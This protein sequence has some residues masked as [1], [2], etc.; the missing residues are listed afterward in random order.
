MKKKKYRDSNI[1]QQQWYVDLIPEYKL[2][3]DYFTDICHQSGIVDIDIVELKKKTGIRKFD[4]NEFVSEV[5]KDYDKYTG[6]EI[7]KERMRVIMEGKK[8]WITGYLEFQWGKENVGISPVVAAVKGGLILLMNHGLLNEAIEKG[9][10]HIAKDAESKLE[11]LALKEGHQQL[12]R[13]GN[14]YQPLATIRLKEREEEEFV[15]NEEG[16]AGETN[17]EEEQQSPFPQDHPPKGNTSLPPL[18]ERKSEWCGPDYD[19]VRNFFV[20]ENKRPEAEAVAF[21]D[22]YEGKKWIVQSEHGPPREIKR[23]KQWQLKAETWIHKARLKEMEKKDGTKGKTTS[24]SFKRI[25]RGEVTEEQI[26]EGL[27]K[28][29]R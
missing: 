16:G 23:T 3:W 27:G 19:D 29:F 25:A 15:F 18:K 28:A 9:F 14:G 17:G 13:V 6:N 22:D 1:W 21:W 2:A 7:L 24:S 20:N 8:L 26:A 10:L 4:L 5:N 12:V 11:A